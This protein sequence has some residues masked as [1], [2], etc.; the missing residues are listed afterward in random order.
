MS[1]SNDESIKYEPNRFLL[2]IFSNTGKK[3]KTEIH[4]SFLLA[5]N[6]GKS[7]I[8]NKESY[9]ISRIMFNSLVGA[10]D[11]WTYHK[12]RIE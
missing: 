3:L 1:E 7:Y 9:S 6:A 12:G 2:M 5:Q 4:N 11:K 10:T 8:I